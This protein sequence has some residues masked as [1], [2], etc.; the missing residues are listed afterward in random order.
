[1]SG[2]PTVCPRFRTWCSGFWRFCPLTH[3]ASEESQYN[4]YYAEH[5]RDPGGRL[6]LTPQLEPGTCMCSTIRSSEFEGWL[7]RGLLLDSFEFRPVSASVSI[8]NRRAE[9]SQAADMFP[10]LCLY[11]LCEDEELVFRRW[12]YCLKPRNSQLG[13]TGLA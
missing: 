13:I 8:S 4:V 9:A 6:H 5:H 3:I 10:L 1:M 12:L 7:Q 11:C 2:F